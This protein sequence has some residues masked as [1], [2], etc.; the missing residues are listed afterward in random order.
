MMPAHP[1]AVHFFHP[2]F[3]DGGVE[4]NIA[5][6]SRE[7][8]RRGLHTDTVTLGVAAEDPRTRV[9]GAPELT[10]LGVRRAMCA[11]IPL[12]KHL[13]RHRPD[14]LLAF[15]SYGNVIAVLANLLAG[16]PTRVIVSERTALSLERGTHAALRHNNP[17]KDRVLLGLMRVCYRVADLVSANSIDGARDVERVLGLPND[18]V[19]VLYNPTFDPSVRL[20][21]SAPVTH[22]FFDSPTPDPAQGKVPVLVAAG[23]LNP[24]KD[25]ATLL[26]AFALLRAQRPCRLIIVGEGSE[27]AVLEALATTLGIKADVDFPGFDPNPWRY[28]VRADVFVLSSLWEGL[29]NVLIEAVALGVPV[30]STDCLS[31]PREIL[32]EGRGGVLVTPGDAVGLAAALR[33]ALADPHRAQALARVAQSGLPRFETAPAVEAYLQT[34]HHVVEQAPRRGARS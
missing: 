12:A 10:D 6:L 28:M 27:R 34:I 21:A 18:S 17:L 30:V 23:R 26:R 16:R 25:F 8:R 5:I 11:V 24:Q 19:R 1:R 9:D 7:F 15:Q 20:N 29:P 22:P 2:Y 13:R 3:R 14:V 31:G 33:E 32:L 4:R